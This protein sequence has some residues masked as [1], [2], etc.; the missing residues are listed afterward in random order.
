MNRMAVSS[1]VAQ[2][3]I[4][5]P[6]TML[7]IAGS[8]ID[9]STL[10]LSEL[11][12]LFQKETSKLDSLTDQ[13]GEAS[14]NLKKLTNL[15]DSMA[16]EMSIATQH[17]TSEVVASEPVVA[18]DNRRINDHHREPQYSNDPF[19]E[20]HRP[21]QQH[22]EQ[23]YDRHDGRNPLKRAN[24]SFDG[25]RTSTYGRDHQQYQPKAGRNIDRNI[26]RPRDRN[27][28]RSD[29]RFNRSY[30]NESHFHD[31]QVTDSVD[32]VDP[33]MQKLMPDDSGFSSQATSPAR[34]LPS[35]SSV[36][37]V[38]QEGDEWESRPSVASPIEPPADIIEPLAVPDTVNYSWGLAAVASVTEFVVEDRR[39]LYRYARKPRSLI[40]P[41]PDNS[42]LANIVTTGSLDGSI[43][44]LDVSRMN[45]VRTAPNTM[46]RNGSPEDICWIGNDI[47][48]VAAGRNSS[49]EPDNIKLDQQMTLIY[50]CSFKK[51]SMATLPTL[52]FEI[53]HLKEHPHDTNHQGYDIASMARVQTGDDYTKWL[54]GGSDHNVVMWSFKGK[55]LG[56]DSRITTQRIHRAHTSMVHSV[57]YDPYGG[58]VYTGGADSRFIGWDVGRESLLFG[59]DRIS[60]SVRDVL[61]HPINP[62]LIVVSLLAENNESRVFDTRTNGYVLTV[63][64]R[65]R[66]PNPEYRQLSRYTHAS[67]SLDGNYLS[68]GGGNTASNSDLYIWDLRYSRV[69]DQTQTIGGDGTDPGGRVLRSAFMQVDG[70]EKLITLSSGNVANVI[71]YRTNVLWG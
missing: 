52:E 38:K 32:I 53:E 47:L 20:P 6:R 46:L 56:C 23:H 28:P 43:Q 31:N 61:L 48:A 70:A 35:R 44:W 62:R 54:T 45:V 37:V 36:W 50:N 13:M 7:H 30:D 71:S 14:R 55:F 49:N 57:D 65:F 19:E 29:K 63:Q 34:Q 40:T 21:L 9:V 41:P 27:E 24:E 12:I 8:D 25:R 42:E 11:S 69:G 15:I 2:P 51:R 58:I 1:T 17:D 60:H 39:Q 5:R 67:L 3:V 4:K 64:S 16:F 59:Q 33:R 66:F 68:L 26:V 18:R 22:Y 10:T